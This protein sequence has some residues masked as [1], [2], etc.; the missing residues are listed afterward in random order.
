MQLMEAGKLRTKIIRA[1]GDKIDGLVNNW[2]QSPDIKKAKVV[3]MRFTDQSARYPYNYAV[4]IVY[5]FDA[6]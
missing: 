2:L 3:E 1:E 4:L 6:Q 5:T